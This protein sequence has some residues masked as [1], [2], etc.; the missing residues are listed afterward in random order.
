MEDYNSLKGTFRKTNFE[1]NSP[2]TTI[3]KYPLE[4]T[5]FQMIEMPKGATALCT[6]IDD[7]TGMLCVWAKVDTDSPKTQV[8]FLIVGTGVPMHEN[9]FGHEKYV[10]TAQ[11]GPF[12]WH[13]FQI[14]HS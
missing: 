4:I 14:S 3:Y 13:V 12:V 11:M 2:M 5:D 10:G 6:Q 1:N 7:K 9:P 8:E